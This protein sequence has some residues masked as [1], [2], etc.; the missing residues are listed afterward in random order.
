MMADTRLLRIDST[1]PSVTAAA[2]A[3]ACRAPL[4]A[5]APALPAPK[6]VF[7]IAALGFDAWS[8]LVHEA[9]GGEALGGDTT[10]SA[11]SA[12][13]FTVLDGINE[14]N[15]GDLSAVRTE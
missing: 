1:A 6:T 3:E 14:K 13:G 15:A 8:R 10:V 9:I 11:V 4:S 2:G 5:G 7:D 12:T